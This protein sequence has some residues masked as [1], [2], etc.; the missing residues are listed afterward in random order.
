MVA[1]HFLRFQLG[2]SIVL[3]I[4][5]WFL[6]NSHGRQHIFRC[7]CGF[8]TILVIP[9]W[10][11]YIYFGP[12]VIPLKSLCSQFSFSTVLEVSTNI[13]S[14]SL[15]VPTWFLHMSWGPQM[16]PPLFSQPQRY[17]SQLLSVPM[18]FLH[19]S[20][21]TTGFFHNCRGPHIH[22]IGPHMVPP[23]FLQ[24]PHVSS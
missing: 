18:W 8:C 15:V 3:A 7:S 1:T 5:T 22:Y 13:F 12:H 16:I 20:C 9:I 11:D 17:L 19:S 10:F 23:K 14:S 21:Y 2:S 24:S 4:P 6:H